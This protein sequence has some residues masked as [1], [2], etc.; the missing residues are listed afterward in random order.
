MRSLASSSARCRFAAPWAALS[1]HHE[2]GGGEG[3]GEGAVR[4]CG[5]GKVHTIPSS[6]TPERY[7]ASLCSG[8]EGGEAG[9][10]VPAVAAPPPTISSSAPCDLAVAL[11]RSCASATASCQEASPCSAAGAGAEGAGL[12]PA[13]EKMR[14]DLASAWC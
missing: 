4:A 11:A 3:R 7:R 5:K 1:V 13:S 12:S 2:E 10:R 6:R 8:G 9:L 14:E